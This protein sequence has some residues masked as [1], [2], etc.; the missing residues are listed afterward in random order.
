MPEERPVQAELGERYR[1]RGSPGQARG[2][3]AWSPV[4]VIGIVLVAASLVAIGAIVAID[5]VTGGP[6]T[7][8]RA[9]APTPTPRATPNVIVVGKTDPPA[10]ANPASSAANPA[11]TST[12]AAPP[13]LPPQPSGGGQPIV[14]PQ[15]P[16]QQ[17]S[18][19][20]PSEPSAPAADPGTVEPSP[21]TTP[22]QA[23]EP[24]TTPAASGSPTVASTPY[25]AAVT[26][27]MTRLTTVEDKVGQLL[28]LAWIGG[29]A[30]AA[31]PALSELRA[32]GIVHVQNASTS[33][34]ATAIN[35]G[36]KQ[37][38][39]DAN[40]TEPL[41]AID[42]E[43]GI[44]QRIQDVENLRSNWEFALTSPSDLEA[45]QRG[46]DHAQVLRAMGFSMNLAPV[47][48]VN[49][50]PANPVIG[51]RSYSDKP[52]VVA[53]LGTQYILG[54][55]GG[56]IAAV[57]KHFPGHGNT[58]VDSHVGLPSLP[59]TVEQ[60]DEI[61]LVPFRAAIQNDV[62]AIMSAH[63][64]F[65]AVDAPGVPATLSRNVMTGILRER[66]G[67]TGL[68]VSDDMGAMRAI[69]DNFAP[70]EAAVKAVQA[71]VDLL[72]LSAELPRQQAA[73]NALV[74]AVGSGQI[75]TER[76]DQAVRNVLT[77]KARF[78]LLEGAPTPPSRACS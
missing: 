12:G 57:G 38:A 48:D 78:G 25:D 10:G 5:A 34:E 70:G 42:H 54:L 71:G 52:D 9:P 3:S 41:I 11:P 36:L 19:G 27:A 77:V 75:S 6:L 44:V 59:M 40:L 37:I 15:S 2:S 39:R 21:A 4:L 53:R 56:G 32:G 18:V 50:N 60:L 33:V 14:N 1:A 26:R 28:L 24:G 58:S 35:Q 74:E 7:T 20:Q 69:T 30:E 43:G 55:Q 8:A 22:A 46:A 61:E 67:F 64:V 31:R 51:R 49:N 16:G 65:P 13:L 68:A 45:C 63:I 17:P 73:R 29:T 23:V 76:L 72:I 66:L 47:L 62:A